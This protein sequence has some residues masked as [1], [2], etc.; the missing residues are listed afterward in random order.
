MP[1]SVVT[2]VVGDTAEDRVKV[3]QEVSSEAG[4]SD[5]G[6]C[7]KAEL[8]SPEAPVVKEEAMDEGEEEQKVVKKEDNLNDSSMEV[9]DLITSIECNEL[10]KKFLEKL[11]RKLENGSEET[12]AYQKDT[13]P[14]NLI[15]E[16]Q[17]EI[18]RR[19][20]CISNIFR[21]LSFIPGNDRE[22]SKHPGFLALLG[23]LLLLRHW[24][25]KRDK[26]R[27]KFDRE[28]TSTAEDM[29]EV[30]EDGSAEWWWDTLDGLRENTLVILANISGHLNLSVLSE[31]I[32]MPVLNGLLHW[33]ICPSACAVDPLPTMASSSILSPQRLVL[34]ALCKLCV[35]D[36]NVD[37]LL[38]TPPFSRIVLL[39]VTLVRHLAERGDQV[40][41]EF[42][43]VLLSSLVQGDSSA[44]RAVALQQ[45]SI[46]LLLDF[47]ETAEQ[48]A[49]SMVN[50]HGDQGMRM[51]HDNPEMM[52][53]SLDMLRRGASTLKHLAM[54][55]ENRSLFMPQQARLLTLVMSRVL[56]P[57]VVSSLAH[58]LFS[59]SQEDQEVAEANAAID[60]AN[61][62][63]DAA[64]S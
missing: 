21:N 5:S 17:D 62:A 47:I 27:H 38:A 18:G 32:C 63:A 48:A 30:L 60:S 53:T 55:P 31:D 50:S 3:K 29:E 41:R 40:L 6:V 4:E 57:Q 43:I 34:E 22:M 58:V 64:A 37:L 28:P 10:D 59:C 12:E 56:D 46:S 23:R 24:H 35:T 36:T 44:A 15:E 25:A 54:V 61:N 14:L 33:A 13:P 26:A 8:D 52:G 49:L 45:P 16:G 20:I 42:A 9:K 11:K 7:V 1:P 39:F 51:L 2:G 19:C